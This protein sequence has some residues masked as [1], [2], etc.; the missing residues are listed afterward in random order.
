MKN[1]FVAFVLAASL[2]QAAALADGNTGIVRGVVKSYSTGRPIAN[3]R[4]AWSNP[5]GIGWTMTDRNGRFYFFGVTPGVTTVSASAVGSQ[6]GCSLQGTVDP[7]QTIDLSMK[8]S[9]ARWSTYQCSFSYIAGAR[10]GYD[11]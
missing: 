4:V 2:T 5:S 9:A 3:A 1:A 7:N 10:P 11:F 8:L 6:G